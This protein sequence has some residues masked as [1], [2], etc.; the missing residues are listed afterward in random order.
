MELKVKRLTSTSSL[1]YRATEGSAGMDLYADLVGRG[2]EMRLEAKNQEDVRITIQPHEVVAI[3]TG[4]ALGIPKGYECQ[5]RPRSGLAIKRGITVANAPGT[6]DSDYRGEVKVLLYNM[7]NI[8]QQ[9]VHGERVAQLVLARVPVVT[10][11]EVS[12]LSKTER[13]PKGLGSSGTTQ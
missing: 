5:V 3:P 8:S 2:G 4:L 9:I 7:S 10:L 13:G 6:I 11:K 12:Q 1:P